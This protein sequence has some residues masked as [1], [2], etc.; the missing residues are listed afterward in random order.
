MFKST[1]RQVSIS[2]LERDTGISEL[3][4]SQLDHLQK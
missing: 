2:L 1:F 3:N 4:L